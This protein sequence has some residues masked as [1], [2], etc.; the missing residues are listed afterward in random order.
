[1]TRA[2]F[3]ISI[4]QTMDGYTLRGMKPDKD[5]VY[6]GIPLAVIGK[7]SRNRRYYLPDSFHRC[8]T[9][10]NSAF[11][12]KMKAGLEGE[13][14]HPLLTSDKDLPRLLYIDRTRVSHYFKEIY[15]RQTKDGKYT[16]VV[17]DVVPSGPY[18]QFLKESL[19]DGKRNTAFSLR[20]WVDE[21]GNTGGVAQLDMKMLVTFDAVDVGGYA[22]ASKIMATE[23]LI[24]V[25]INRPEIMAAFK[26]CMAV[27]T[28]TN[29]EVLDFLQTNELKLIHN[30]RF[31]VKQ[32]GHLLQSQDGVHST[33]HTMYQPRR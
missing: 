6:R 15:P 23:S 31:L 12:L 8:L 2:N 3:R 26:N 17:G 10:P 27:E 14:C 25:D 9:D 29:Q 18:G 21:V 7:P 19:E 1:M 16:M 32:Q 11:V 4:E 30:Q 13:W 28:I 24:P 33:F 22:E 20:S 5:G